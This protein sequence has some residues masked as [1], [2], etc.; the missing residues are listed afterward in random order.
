[1]ASYDITQDNSQNTHPEK[2]QNLDDQAQDDDEQR[3]ERREKEENNNK[4][5]GL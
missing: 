2:E 3:D 5:M 4:K 1:M